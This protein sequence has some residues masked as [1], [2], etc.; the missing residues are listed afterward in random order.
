MIRS[1]RDN[2]NNK[3]LDSAPREGAVR[4]GDGNQSRVFLFVQRKGFCYGRI[5][6][7]P[8][9]PSTNHHLRNRIMGTALHGALVGWL[10]SLLVLMT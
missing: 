9:V 2:N 7:K 8:C 4:C 6:G 5:T 10:A 3:T 1:P